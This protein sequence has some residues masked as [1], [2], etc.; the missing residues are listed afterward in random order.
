MSA[1]KEQLVDEQA[2]D[3]M[4]VAS[5]DPDKGAS[6]PAEREAEARGS[7]VADQDPL[8]AHPT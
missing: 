6:E 7:G 8:S 4:A 5:P 2:M 3:K 1:E